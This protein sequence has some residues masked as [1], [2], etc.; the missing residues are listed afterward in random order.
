MCP[1][2]HST[3]ESNWMVTPRRLALYFISFARSIALTPTKIS[4]FSSSSNGYSRT[5]SRC[6]H[7]MKCFHV[8][9]SVFFLLYT[10][11]LFLHRAPQ[12]NLGPKLWHSLCFLLARCHWICVRVW[13]HI[14]DVHCW[15]ILLFYRL[16]PVQPS[17]PR[18][19]L[20]Q[21]LAVICGFVRIRRVSECWS[22]LSWQAEAESTVLVRC[23][24]H[25]STWAFEGGME[26]CFHFILS[27]IHSISFSPL[28]TSGG[29]FAP[30]SFVLVTFKE[31]WWNSKSRVVL[32]FH[33]SLPVHFCSM[34]VLSFVS[35]CISVP[36]C[37]ESWR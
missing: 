5:K 7:F 35:R 19:T 28:A 33:S 11:S 17:D 26:K 8:D 20:P 12:I 24:L 27:P 22:S 32:S 36:W 18:W 30:S 29:F 21:A 4:L 25:S 23:K 37:W 9:I 2:E 1:L 3:L 15:Y 13:S 6:L 16:V 10:A 34:S 31:F 14:L